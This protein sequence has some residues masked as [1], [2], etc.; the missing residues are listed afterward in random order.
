MDG[1]AVEIAG[2]KIRLNGIDAPETD[3]VCLDARGRRWTCGVAARVAL[4]QHAGTAA[5]SCRA[6]DTDRYGRTVASCTVAGEDVNRWMVRA[7]WALAFVRYSRAYEGDEDAAREARAGLWAGVFIAPW[8]W[9]ARSTA[10]VVHGAVS[11]PANALAI[12]LGTAPAADAP[13]PGCAIKG[14]VNRAGECLYHVPGGRWYAKVHMDLSKGKRW[15]CSTAEAE[16]A[17]CR[18]AKQ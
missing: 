4:V 5:W 17:G 11:V 2:T 1:D 15:F 9:R 16:A 13:S 14:N 10:S 18:A 8:D 12:L 6:T 7:G 3:Q